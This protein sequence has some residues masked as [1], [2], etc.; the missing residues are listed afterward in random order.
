MKLVLA[1]LL[2]IL[3]LCFA[4]KGH[5]EPGFHFTSKNEGGFEQRNF[6]NILDHFNPM[7]NRTY[8]QRYWFSTDKFDEVNNKKFSPK[9]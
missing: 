4:I 2:I 5:F 8:T 7:D 3:G 1:L 6:T 9:S